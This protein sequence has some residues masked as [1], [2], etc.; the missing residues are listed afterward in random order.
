M[1]RFDETKV[2]KE[3]FY[4]AKKYLKYLIR[5]LDKVI[6]LLVL[7]MPKMNGYIETFKVKYK[8]NELMSLH[9]DDEKLLAN[10]KL[11]GLRLKI[12][13]FD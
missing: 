12:Y 8:N 6:R 1:L 9:I 4:G 11:F 5:Y 7:A 10:I 2:A 13:I 3:K